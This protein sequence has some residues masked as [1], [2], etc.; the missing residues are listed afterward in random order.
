MGL[1]SKLFKRNANTNTQTQSCVNYVKPF[2]DGLLFGTYNE[3]NPMSLSAVFSAIEII[4]NSLAELPILVKHK[5]NDCN[6]IDN[7]HYVNQLFKRMNMSKFMFIKKL[8]TDMLT[9]GNGFAYIKRDAE[10]QPVELVYLPKGSVTVDYNQATGKLR[11]LATSYNWIPRT[12]EPKDVIHL[13]KNTR[14]GYNGIG[15]LAYANRTIKVS[16]YAEEATADY[17]GSGC[18][19]KGIIKATGQGAGG[20]L[21]DEQKES[22]RSSWQQ[23]HGGQ[24]ASGL[25]V[26]PIN[27]DF[28]P[29]SQ[30]ASESQMIETRTFNISEVARF[31]NISPVLLQDLSH[32][33]YSTIEASQLEYLVHT[34]QPYISLMEC[35]FNRKLIMD[36]NYFID[37]DEDYLMTAD[38]STTANYLNTLV[39][40]GIL[41]INEARYQLGY[42]PIEGGDKHIIPFTNLEQNTINKDKNI[43]EKE[44]D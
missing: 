18:N 11:Y 14:D 22:I 28:V 38:K 44:N 27:M 31:F 30:N 12:L 13:Y 7:T 2:S 41:C 35:E 23:V 40:G 21:T 16:N 17:F 15:I 33:S 29:V 37:L 3:G 8:I 4:S 39:K 36:D 34:L 24:G 1:F 19:I 20:R 26:M 5:T 42:G 6:D 9:N 43:E 32:S 25:A 10:G